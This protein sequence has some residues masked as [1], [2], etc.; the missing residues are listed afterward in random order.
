MDTDIT[1]SGLKNQDLFV[2]HDFAVNQVKLLRD[3]EK[4]IARLCQKRIVARKLD[5][6]F[7][8]PSYKI[9]LDATHNLDISG[10]TNTNTVKTFITG[11]KGMSGDLSNYWFKELYHRCKNIYLRRLLIENGVQLKAI[12]Q[13]DSYDHFEAIRTGEAGPDPLPVPFVEVDPFVT[14]PVD[15]TQSVASTNSDVTLLVSDAEEEQLPTSVASSIIGPL[16]SSVGT[17]SF[18]KTICNT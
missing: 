9:W 6:I 15:D 3:M 14:D 17:G 12:R 13:D 2:I 1:F 16:P 4:S 11:R 18:T 10:Q 5:L 8:S 7:D